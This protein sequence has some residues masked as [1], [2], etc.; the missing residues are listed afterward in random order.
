MSAWFVPIIVALIAGPLMWML[1][2]L[3]RRNTQQHGDSINRLDRID[4]KLDRL[5]DRLHDHITDKKGH[6]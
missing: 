6:R 5:T 1:H 4:G 2:R 3:D